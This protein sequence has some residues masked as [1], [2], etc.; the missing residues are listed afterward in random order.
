MAD[1]TY[2]LQIRLGVDGDGNVTASLAGVAKGLDEVKQKS[3]AATASA[4]GTAGAL[5]GLFTAQELV[6]GAKWIIE[7]IAN[8]E[9]L[10][11]RLR[12]VADNQ[13]EVNEAQAIARQI[14]ADSAN[15][16]DQ[17]TEAYIALR[18]RG[19][20]PSESTM[21]SVANIAAAT[22]KS[23]DDVA[24]IIGNA[25]GGQVRSL[26]QL[27]V[28]VEEHD[29]KLIA[30]FRGVREEIGT[31]ANDIVDYLKRI[32]ETQYA[33]AAIRESQ[34]LAGEWQHL[35]QGV[36]DLVDVIGEAGLSDALHAV[37]RW[38]RE[39]LGDL[40]TDMAS[41]VAQT[42][43]EVEAIAALVGGIRS[44]LSYL[45]NNDS[46]L[47]RALRFSV[48]PSMAIARD[49]ASAQP[50][51]FGNVVAGSS[52]ADIGRNSEAK[53][54]N[55]LATNTLTDAESKL[56]KATAAVIE[57]MQRQ[58][59]VAT[60][61][62]GAAI[63]YA[64][65]QAAAKAP[66][67]EQR[68]KILELGEA[69]AKEADAKQRSTD[70]NKAS[71]AARREQ[72]AVDKAHADGLRR[73]RELIAEEAAEL[74]AAAERKK[75]DAEHTK[76][77]IEAE[78]LLAE[79]YERVL[80][81]I[82]PAGDKV[83]ALQK[84]YD[85]LK[86]AKERY[87]EGGGDRGDD[88]IQQQNKALDQLAEKIR[89]AED[90]ADRARGILRLSG[91]LST[92][93]GAPDGDTSTLEGILTDVAHTFTEAIK[94]GLQDAGESFGDLLG[95]IGEKLLADVIQ[96]K[97]VNN[98]AGYAGGGKL[99]TQDLYGGLAYGG[100]VLIGGMAGGGGERAGQ[101]AAL[102][103]AVGTAIFPVIGTIVGAILGG[104]VGGMFE[105]Q[106]RAKVY[107]GGDSGSS[108]GGISAFGRVQ[109]YTYGLGPQAEQQLLQALLQLDN[110]IAKMLTPGEI[111]AVKTA[112]QG[113][114]F[115]A[116][117]PDAV[118]AARLNAIIA[119]VE[120]QWAAFLSKF[121]DLESKGQA[122]AALRNLREQVESFDDLLTSI[123][124][125][126][127]EQLR[128]QMA[129]FDK[130]VKDTGQALEDAIAS[131]DPAR[132]EQAASAAVQAVVDRY[133]AEIEMAQQLEAALAAA[134]QQA[135]QLKMSIEQ[136]IAGITGDTSRMQSLAM[137]QITSLMSSIPGMSLAQGLTGLN[138][139]IGSV[140][141]WRSA[142][143]TGIQNWMN[144]QLAQLAQ[145]RANLQAWA[146]AEN[147]RMQAAAESANRRAQEARQREIDALQKQLALA[148]QWVQ[149]L[150]HADELTRQL[151][152]SEANPLG[153]YGQLEA[154]NQ[155]IAR[156]LPGGTPP[157]E[158][159]AD[160]ANELLQL[161]QQRMQLLQ[162]TD[163]YQRPSGGYLDQYNQTLALI[164]QV[165]QLA[166]PGVDESTRLQEELVALQNK[167]I[168]TYSAGTVDITAQL[169]SI[170][171]QEEAVRK[172]AE[173]KQK[174]IDD[175]A[176]SY[177]EW[178][179]DEAQRL[180]DARQ[181]E[182]MDQLQELTGGLP[183]Q[184]FIAKKQA[185]ATELLT[186]IRD[187]IRDFLNAIGGASNTTRG[188]GG[189]SSSGG[190]GRNGGNASGTQGA[191]NV[192]PMRAAPEVT[193]NVTINAAGMTQQDIVN[194]VHGEFRTA[195]SDFKRLIEVA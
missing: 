194:V 155:A 2:N 82:D 138:E 79:A 143:I 165:R 41:F 190:G 113:Q 19:L 92:I 114:V 170:S 89:K 76:A 179:R 106:A 71:A 184:E 118:L 88:W 18:E 5:V 39:G 177:Y 43:R 28:A 140:D 153:G 182:L 141:Q 13:Q 48:N 1:R 65:A 77:M 10:S 128:M 29:G 193:M 7:S 102:G 60:E 171:E 42:K 11:L 167:A 181:K 127:V 30:T 73:T 15:S 56:G 152:F 91:L 160:Q 36:S 51:N 142:G 87:L 31:T 95:R 64:A 192:V 35:K 23:I 148:Q 47:M 12:A 158:M 169:Q 150:E 4:K 123:N 175:Q 187:D 67:E 151:Q 117:N 57:Q 110:T 55:A 96:N 52:T 46:T 20:A 16:V 69:L 38:F 90:E 59:L 97:I 45:E 58:L 126:P 135:Y 134:K 84:S 146:A 174:E 185:E 188:S 80:G 176:L 62:Q 161:L 168:A 75:E 108:T 172:E 129:A 83:R 68:Q 101:G 156:L 70:A 154:I 162:S 191:S 116:K 6:N 66:T 25:I 133:R 173:A 78:S 159:D 14:A 27:G 130:Q 21:R 34:S 100:G 85:D 32:G 178:A 186:N 61:G 98:L 195:A 104:L 112:L 94:D 93:T 103:A 111:E 72:A 3:D 53:T 120:P 164:D 26:Q 136:R 145:Q 121:E 44:M 54:R 180:E 50:A 81:I 33:D 8:A 166:Q 131:Q 189:S 163:L 115:D 119:A 40:S 17:V 86:A 109:S 24:G 147:A 149:V 74:K 144:A 105:K 157:Q 122:F 132:I 9:R 139:F 37:V 183:V 49:L 125:T 107:S 63:R 124:G 99:N 22:G 137:G